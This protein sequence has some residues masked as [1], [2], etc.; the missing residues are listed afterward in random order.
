MK[1]RMIR[2]A[3]NSAYA[4]QEYIR[5]G[6]PPPR[7]SKYV[8]GNAKS[9]FEYQVKL[10]SLRDAQIRHNALES[11]RMASNKPLS[12]KLGES[13]YCLW[14]RVYPHH[15]IRENKMMAFAGADRIQKG[16]RLAFGKPVG[17]AARVKNGQILMIAYVNSNGVEIAKQA[18]KGGA[19]KLPI[20]CRVEVERLD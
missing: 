17:T 15:V 2:V 16:M 20:P 4:R 10:I 9:K 11:A 18:L 7:I 13:D 5:G 14:I 1:G 6:V 12:L 19:H 3:D 8:M